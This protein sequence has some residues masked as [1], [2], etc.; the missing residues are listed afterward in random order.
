MDLARSDAGQR[1]EVS[2]H[3]VALVAREAV[4]R[5]PN[6]EL[7]HARITRGLRQDGGRG[8]GQT[9]LVALENAF[10]RNGE[11]VDLPAVDE[12]VL[13]WRRQSLDGATHRQDPGPVD[14]H[15]ID[16]VRLDERH[17]PRNG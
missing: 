16:L 12:N 9:S 14:V 4:T 13:G 8:D 7:H 10:L 17:R 15:A 11:V 2:A 3:R 6:V 5:K 1:V